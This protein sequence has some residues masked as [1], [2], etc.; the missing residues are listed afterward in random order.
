MHHSTS[1]S[2]RTPAHRHRAGQKLQCTPR[3]DQILKLCF[4]HLNKTKGFY[5][6]FALKNIC[7]HYTFGLLFFLSLSLREDISMLEVKTNQLLV[8][9]IVPHSSL[10]CESVQ[11]L[12][13]SDSPTFSS[14]IPDLFFRGEICPC[15]HCRWQCKNFTSGVNFSRN[16]AVCYMNESKKSHFI[17]ISSSKLL[18]YY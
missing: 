7:K 13:V 12:I 1:T 14:N 2:C 10:P 8:H 18:A 3:Q 16:N 11:W 9:Y 6:C 15:H 5:F 4:S 17:L